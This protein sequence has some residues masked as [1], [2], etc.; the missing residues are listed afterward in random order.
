MQQR[1][2][3]N[4]K[5]ELIRKVNTHYYDN[6]KPV[7]TKKHYFLPAACLLLRLGLSFLDECTILLPSISSNLILSTSYPAISNVSSILSQRISLYFFDIN[8]FD[9]S[10]ISSSLD[11]DSYQYIIS[12]RH[13]PS[14]RASTFALNLLSLDWESYLIV[15]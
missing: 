11:K 2:L 5:W 13:V 3:N 8:I 14:S 10:R 12:P 7:S 4:E 9:V 15:L 1:Q 6:L